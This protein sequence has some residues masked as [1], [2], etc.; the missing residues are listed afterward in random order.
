MATD[1]R[2]GRLPSS[3][4][5]E[6]PPVP[7]MAAQSLSEQANSSMKSVRAKK[8]KKKKKKKKKKRNDFGSLFGI[9]CTRKR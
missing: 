7:W 3:S 6:H 5:K 8:H 1:A 4:G 2:V 9:L